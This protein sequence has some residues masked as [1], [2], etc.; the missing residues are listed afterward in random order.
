MI[1][2]LV[3]VISLAASLLAVE[4][5]I[6]DSTDSKSNK[7]Y[8]ET[9][10]LVWQDDRAGLTVTRT[11]T[12]S[13]RYCQDL[14][15]ENNSDWRLPT[16][17]ELESIVD[18]TKKD[19]TINDD[20]VNI[21]SAEYW[22]SSQYK[23]SKKLAWS[24]NFKKSYSYGSLKSGK[25]HIR[26]VRSIKPIAKK[27]KLMWQDDLATK[28]VKF[29]YLSSRNYCSNL[30]LDGYQNWKLPTVNQLLLI[31]NRDTSKPSIVKHIKNISSS[32]YWSISN[33]SNN[34]KKAWT[35]DFKYGDNYL[36]KKDEKNNVRCVR[37]S[38]Y[39]G[40]DF[41]K[42]LSILVEEELKS[43]PK[44]ELQTKLIR[45]EF[46]ST[47]EFDKR[48]TDT[49]NNQKKLSSNHD[50]RYA[51]LRQKAK[52]TGIKRALEITWGKPILSNLKYDPDN[53][54]FI[55]NITFESK[56]DFKKKVAI[57]VDNKIARNF[58]EAFSTLKPQAIFE[59]DESSIKLKDINVPYKNN[60]YL[61]KFTNV[62]IDETRVA[63]NISVK[64]AS[65]VNNI[66]LVD[67]KIQSL[68]INSINNFNELDNALKKS[69]QV[70]NDRTKW[71]FVIGIEKYDYTDNIVYAKRSA[72]MFSKIIQKK[73][74]VS[75]Q[76]SFIL[77]NEE[78]S[79][80]KIKTSMKKLLRRVKN[81]DTI[82]FYYNGHGVPVPA[83]KNEPYMLSADTEP[84][85]IADEKFF[86]LSNIYSTLSSSKADKVIAFVDS[87]FSG[88]TDGKAVLKGVAATKM[89]AKSVKFNKE[90]MVVITAGKGN[91]Y[92][93]GY[94]TKAHRLF[95]FF[96]MKNL[97]DGDT[98]IKSLFKK[99]K[100]Q[101]YDT[102]LEEY[103]DSRVQE[104]TINGNYRMSL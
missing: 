97:I 51:D 41:E 8:K 13:S 54:Y 34:V 66:S 14:V 86:S 104:P 37:V 20:F 12:D 26:C 42:L 27:I 21:A 33:A 93:N 80:A 1:K 83:L 30:K 89:V 67:N 16:I 87:C 81:G 70:K 99:V 53:G 82:Y 84:D 60:D 58:K 75:K 24:V 77:I 9:S 49:K 45:G 72:Q 25:N 62:N 47:K 3:L 32:R 92:S 69:Q 44:L 28:K 74:G 71:L 18:Y 40:Y 52:L 39:D 85:Y 29:D 102:S 91:Q 79:Q 22:S 100:S 7:S 94:D 43:L 35:V 31:A 55:A 90:K 78:A 98:E 96:V 95:S 17:G 56:P 63:V 48:V 11:W 50:A 76:N 4:I 65:S 23:K 10:G 88:V 36:D 59:Y 64:H 19:K 101:T 73:F 68:D 5:I 2:N 15:L 61:A 46:E 57:K 38:Q 6:D 103:G